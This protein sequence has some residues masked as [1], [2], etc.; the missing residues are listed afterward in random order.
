M[1]DHHC[2]SEGHAPQCFYADSNTRDNLVRLI[3]LELPPPAPGFK[4]RISL[5]GNPRQRI[6]I[7]SQ[8]I[9]SQREA[10]FHTDI[11]QLL[12]L[13][14]SSSATDARDMI[15]AFY[16][17]TYLTSAVSYSRS[18]EDLFVEATHHYIN[19]LRYEASYRSVHSLT[20]EQKVFQLMS[21]IYS[22]GRLHQHHNLPSW[23]P[24]WTFSWHLAPVWA[25]G[26]PNFTPSSGKDEWSLGI[27][28]G[29]RA[30]GDVLETF[31]ILE[32]SRSQLRLSALI[33][34][35]ILLVDELT[36]A[37]TPAA[38]QELPSPGGTEHDTPEIRY[39]RHFFTTE[40]GH[41]GMATP[42]IVTGDQCAILLAGDVPVVLRPCPDPE[43]KSKI[44]KLLCECYIQNPAVMSGE[45]LRNN[46]TA[47]EDIVLM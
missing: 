43:R 6:A 34:D 38:S 3:R 24:D 33:F 16:G 35:S 47:A 19:A 39:G 5:L 8:M 45:L 12:I 46:W 23:I 30:G 25:S 20:E 2:L 17:L 15:Y 31:D 7:I 18:P 11:T 29:H 36:P 28:S 41:V 4:K 44:Y 9:A 42:G 14:K 40:G 22:A 21:I 1:I 10:L 26:V 13:G 32:G 37:S 27:R